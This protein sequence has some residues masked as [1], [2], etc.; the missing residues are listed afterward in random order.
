M[1]LVS[2]NV[3]DCGRKSG[4]FI[5]M[6]RPALG[7]KS[8]MYT[9]AG[10]YHPALTPLKLLLKN[11]I[12]VD[13]SFVF[14]YRAI[15]DFETFLESKDLPQSKE[16]RLQDKINLCAHFSVSVSSNVPDYED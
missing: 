12:S 1:P 4:F 8:K 13:T 15:Y 3:E 14:P 11:G 2:R 9:P 5:A 7:T 6:R 16:R 10:V